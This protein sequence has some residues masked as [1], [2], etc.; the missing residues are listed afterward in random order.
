VVSE[1]YGLVL[2]AGLAQTGKSTFIHAALR[3]LS[4][5]KVVSLEN[6]V[7]VAVPGITQVGYDPSLGASFAETLQ[8]LLDQNPE[9]IHAG[10]IRDLATA[11]IALRAALTGRKV[12]A[13]VHAVDAVSGIRRLLD[14][15]VAPGRLAESLTGVVSLRLVRRLC[16]DCSRPFDPEAPRNPREALLAQLSGVIPPR[17]AVGCTRCW[18]TGFRG[19]L[20]VAEVL[21]LGPETRPALSAGRDDSEMERACRREGMLS[22]AASA[23]ERV[24]AGET[25]LREVERALGFPPRAPEAPAPG[26]ALVVDDEAGDR[27]L[28]GAVLAG[29]G[30]EVVEAED[31]IAALTL[32]EKIRPSLVVLDLGLPGMPGREVLGRI[33]SAEVT[34]GVP[35]IV[36]TGSSRPE[37]EILL[38]DE[39]ADDY[40]LKPVV[41][42]RLE[43][44]VRAVLRRSGLTPPAG[45]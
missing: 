36:L 33:R 10:E 19:Q 24:R 5:A 20:P 12:L 14:M 18:N 27:L 17:E 26:P 21:I 40:V 22:L 41:N 32:L 2:V 1:R 29:M 6:P 37:D 42:S 43:A 7:E 35:V 34:R 38:L 4:H 25:T 44:R 28:V 16:P 31:G 13:T 11:R 30:L 8:G 23:L 3:A 39:G 9:V 45:G 15:G